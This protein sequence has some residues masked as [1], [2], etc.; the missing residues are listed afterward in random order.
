MATGA[1]NA[2]VKG[3]RSEE[4]QR[5]RLNDIVA[6]A[7]VERE[8]KGEL[9]IE[10]MC[11]VSVERPTDS[12]CLV[13][14]GMDETGRASVQQQWTD[15]SLSRE[16]RGKGCICGRYDGRGERKSRWPIMVGA[17]DV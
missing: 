6:V 8:S 5:R 15:F 3:K 17:G 13:D 16:G 12:E 4:E 2:Y 9:T 10:G 14:G 11:P 1:Y 7:V